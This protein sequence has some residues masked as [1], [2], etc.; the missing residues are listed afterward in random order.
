MPLPAG[1]S[2]TPKSMQVQPPPTREDIQ[3]E[4]DNFQVDKEWKWD[5]EQGV[6]PQ[7][8]PPPTNAVGWQPNGQAYYGEGLSG[9]WNKVSGKVT[10]A[11]NY[12][13]DEGLRISDLSKSATALKNY[14]AQ[15]LTGSTIYETKKKTEADIAKKEEDTKAFSEKVGETETGAVILGVAEAAKEALNQA[16]WTVLD[17]L[18]AASV[19]AEQVLGTAGYTLADVVS[20]EG[21]SAQQ[22][23]K[24]WN[25]SRMAY[26]TVFDASI[27][28][29]MTR[30]TQSG[31]NVEFAAQEVMAEKKWTMWSETIGQAVLDP[32]NLVAVFTKAGKAIMLRRTVQ[33]QFHKIINPA[34]REVLQNAGKLDE[35][36]A[37]RYTNDVI[38]E[39]QAMSAVYSH[40]DEISKA[41]RALVKGSQS[42]KMG[43]LTST[44]KMSRLANHSS[45]IMMHIANNSDD[46]TEIIMG[47]IKST[48]SNKAEAAEGLAE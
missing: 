15:Q 48:S 13:H 29:E 24:N 44:A 42:Y 19:K 17:G 43:N 6:G 26:S 11:F 4:K 3:F 12:G 31:M 22:F 34:V 30:R 7:G 32:L 20:G 8:E 23:E 40:I 41:D 38:K 10:D 47:M 37:L 46:A 18:G 5:N 33:S 16:V 21:V 9:W 27:Y 35:A 28:D 2:W 45:E 14:S 39:Q 1:Y 36:G 25:A